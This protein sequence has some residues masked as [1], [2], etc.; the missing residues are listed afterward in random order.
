ME[1]IKERAL[2]HEG[3]KHYFIIKF[4]QRH[5]ALKEF[6]SEI[7]D[8]EDDITHFDYSKR[9]FREK[10]HAVVGIEMKNKNNLN[11][12]IERMKER[13]FY[14]DYLNKKENFRQVLI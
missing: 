9:N 14:G 4:P 13:N 6:V 2:L 3:I 11:S 5:G 10:G 7:L 12:L 8:H 1:E